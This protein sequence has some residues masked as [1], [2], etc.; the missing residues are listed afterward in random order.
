M[1]HEK[2]QHP[3]DTVAAAAPAGTFA[4]P[5]LLMP[6]PL[7]SSVC[8]AGLPT[9]AVGVADRFRPG[10]RLRS[11]HC[12]GRWIAVEH[13]TTSRTETSPTPAQEIRPIATPHKLRTA[14]AGVDNRACSSIHDMLFRLRAS[15]CRDVS[16]VR[17]RLS[18]VSSWTLQLF[19]S[20]LVRRTGDGD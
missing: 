1:K 9:N 10:L 12:Q 3:F 11:S 5:R 14:R 15:R 18:A 17:G 7:T 4:P 2:R 16:P 20:R 19:S 13:S 8:R 6:Q